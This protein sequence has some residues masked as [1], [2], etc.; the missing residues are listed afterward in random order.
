M[1]TRLPH[2][3]EEPLPAVSDQL[4]RTAALAAKLL[5]QRWFARAPIWLYR[6]RL[7][8]LMGSRMLMLEHIGRS[9][10]ARRYAILEVVA[11][12]APGRYVVAS[13]FGERSQ[14]FRN[15]RANPSVR[16]WVG[17]HGPRSAV[18]RI[19]APAEAQAALQQ[20]ARKHPRAW[21]SLRP[22]FESTLG[23]EIDETG[24]AL[25]MVSLELS[26]GE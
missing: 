4:R 2:D 17:A 25:P 23:V 21:R 18:A 26:L 1:V 8:F 13:G 6:A 10:G 16:I 7:G 3:L 19:L 15:V 24:T 12:P 11:Q 14:W 20:Y 5:E 22:V 9:S